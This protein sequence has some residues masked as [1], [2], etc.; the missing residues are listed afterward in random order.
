MINPTPTQEEREIIIRDK[1]AR[2]GLSVPDEVVQYIAAHRTTDQALKGAL[3]NLS[4]YAYRKRSPITIQMAQY[5]LEGVRSSIN[6]KHA[7]EHTQELPA[8]GLSQPIEFASAIEQGVTPSQTSK[9]RSYGLPS[10]LAGGVSP[11]GLALTSSGMQLEL[12]VVSDYRQTDT[13]ATEPAPRR[14]SIPRTRPAPRSRTTVRAES[15]SLITPTL[16]DNF[17]EHFLG[18]QPSAPVSASP[19]LPSDAPLIDAPAEKPIT[20]SVTTPPADVFFAPMRTEKKRSF[21]ERTGLA[22]QRA[23][24]AEIITPGDYVAIKVHCG[25]TGNSG[26]VSPIYAR[27]VVRLV[28]ELGGRPFLTDAN[29]LYSG[30]R[31]NAIDHMEC[32]IHNGFSYATVEAPFIVADGLR[33]QSWAEVAVDGKHCQ[34]VRMGAAAVEA[35]AM[36]V[37]SHVKGHGVAGFGGAIKNVGMGLG[38]RGAKQR[39]HSDVHPEIDTQ[40]CTRCQRC[41]KWCPAHAIAID[42]AHN[43]ACIDHEICYGCGE[44]V[45]ACT[46]EAIAVSFQT[47]SHVFQEK[48]VEHAA[49]I[50]NAKAGKMMYLSF[51]TNITPECDCWS[52]SDAPLVPDIGLMTSRDMIA[53]DQA[54]YDKIVQATG[55][56]GSRAEGMGG[57]IDKF[58]EVHGTDGTHALVYGEQFGLGTRRYTL[59]EIG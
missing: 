7:A 25:E 40:K 9:R 51:L 41:V 56:H 16:F 32:A 8:V 29:T 28:K 52:F 10:F 13:Y 35:D 12:N 27:E 30:H 19:N 6:V 39:M 26:F 24:L 22:L 53:I 45:A 17:D 2:E 33:G 58:T 15:E 3:I 44:C 37:I 4:A 59:H 34:S 49:G 57:G 55:N 18:E 5:V 11:I 14:R 54:A 21:V 48:L 50:I 47:D 42:A 36:I 23:G 31:S 38:S 43:A 1:A 20:P 46:S